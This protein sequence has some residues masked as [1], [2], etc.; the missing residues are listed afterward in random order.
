MAALL[1]AAV[2]SRSFAFDVDFFVSA[3]ET[4]VGGEIETRVTVFGAKPGETSL[5]IADIPP[6][7]AQASSRKERERV[8][9]P[10]SPS[11]E[12][13][14][15]TVVTQ[16][17]VAVSPGSVA[18]GPFLVKVENEVVEIPPVHIAIA[19]PRASG[20]TELR[21][22][23]DGGAARSG[24]PTRIVLEASRYGTVDAI[25]C[26]APENALLESMPLPRNA[27]GETQGS[28]DPSGETASWV[29]IAAWDWAPLSVGSVS[30][31][32]AVVEYT[33]PEGETRKAVSPA[34]AVTVSRGN[35]ARAEG[36]LSRSLGRAFMK[37]SPASTDA[38]ADRSSRSV[39]LPPEL[40]SLGDAGLKATLGQYWKAGEYGRVLADLRFAERSRL[41][42][43]RYREARL[44]CEAALAVPATRDV[45]P[46]AWKQIAVVAA[47]FFLSLALVLRL[48]SLRARAVSS[49][50]ALSAVLAL[51]IACFAVVVYARDRDPAGVT[52]RADLYHVP[53]PGSSVVERLPEGLPVRIIKVARD[54]LYVETPTTLRGWIPSKSAFLYT[55]T[56]RP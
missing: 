55:G 18:L 37:P 50:A 17:W 25:F 54:W 46:A 45:P 36:G 16:K 2:C 44:A 15:A 49:L 38:G 7:L 28:A 39:P 3:Y 13:V 31:P 20:K 26:D 52:V 42:P 11:G 21:W 23:L 29:P 51:A 8:A 19:E 47:A 5:E 48:V 43:G 35:G 22:R 34:Y 27:A 41:F 30:L 10:A 56:E 9:N 1:L 32:V 24:E 40:S 33:T 6:A 14:Q 53:D 12:S 4:T